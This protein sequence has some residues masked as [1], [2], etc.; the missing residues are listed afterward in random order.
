MVLHMAG[1]DGGTK[2]FTAAVEPPWHRCVG[3]NEGSRG[4]EKDV[5]AIH[6]RDAGF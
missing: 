6:H 1:H 5:H 3:G 4:T 2:Q